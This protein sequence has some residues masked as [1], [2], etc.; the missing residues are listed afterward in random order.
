M[1]RPKRPAL[2]RRLTELSVRKLKPKADSL[3]DLGHPAARPRHPGAAD[4]R[5]G[6]EVHLLATTA[7]RAG[8]TSA[9]PARS[10]WPTP[11]RW[12]RRPCWRSPG[13]R[14]RRPRSGPSA[15]P[16]PSPS[17]PSATSS[18]YAKKRNKSWKQADTLVQ[19]YLLPRWGKLQ[20]ATITRADVRAMMARIEAP[21]LANQVLAAASRDLHAGRSS[22][23]SSPPTPAAGRAQRDP[24]RERVLSDSEVPQVLDRVRRRRSRRRHPP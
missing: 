5:A 17:W 1:P 12:R 15:A 10:G 18:S 23:R 16:A 2:K 13:A 9:T 11:A 14:T 21:V 8:C 7:D 6:L 4:R 24:S 19:R 20:A 22:R 3:R